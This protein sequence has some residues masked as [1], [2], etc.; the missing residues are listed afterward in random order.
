MERKNERESKFKTGNQLDWQ[1][2]PREFHAE[3]TKEQF[4]IKGSV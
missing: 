4:G 1:F 3:Q 2:V